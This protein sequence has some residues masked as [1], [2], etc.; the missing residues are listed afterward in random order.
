MRVIAARSNFLYI[1]LQTC[2]INLH[3]RDRISLVSH[4]SLRSTEM[5]E[6]SSV[7]NYRMNNAAAVD[8]TLTRNGRVCSF[9][10]IQL[11]TIRDGTCLNR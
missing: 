5:V 11:A 7:T 6:R 9:V 2:K 3:R 10:V 4:S 1:I 8:A